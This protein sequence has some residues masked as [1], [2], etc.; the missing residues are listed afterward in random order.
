MITK[1][2]N[3]KKDRRI[4]STIRTINLSLSPAKSRSFVTGCLFSYLL[5]HRDENYLA[6]Y[7][8]AGRQPAETTMVPHHTAN[9]VFL[10]WCPREKPNPP[11]KTNTCQHHHHHH[12]HGHTTTT[13]DRSPPRKI[14]KKSHK[15]TTN[16][17]RRPTPNRMYPD[18]VIA[19]YGLENA[20]ATHL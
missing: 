4:Q 19:T 6:P 1:R 9:T 12:H 18:T 14:H 8:R 13:T 2:G 11:K 3:E 7:G 20:V 17:R 10:R 16:Y 15:S 5:F